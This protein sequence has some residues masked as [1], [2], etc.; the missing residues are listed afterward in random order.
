MAWGLCLA[1]LLGYIYNWTLSTV[2][3][4]SPLHSLLWQLLCA[5]F[6][7]CQL[8]VGLYVINAQP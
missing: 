2:S 1:V 4:A 7:T 3:S 6:N 5:D 8:D